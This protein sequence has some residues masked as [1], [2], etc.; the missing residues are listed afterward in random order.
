MESAPQLSEGQGKNSGSRRQFRSR[1]VTSDETWESHRE[2]IYR[3]YVK[4]KNTLSQ[5][6]QVMEATHKFKAR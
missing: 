1:H 5:T 3:I 4:E 2:E 6:M